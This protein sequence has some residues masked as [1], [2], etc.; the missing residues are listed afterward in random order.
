MLL[1]LAFGGITPTQARECKT[2]GEKNCTVTLRDGRGIKTGTENRG[3]DGKV[4]T[5]DSRGVKTGTIQTKP[6]S[7]CEIIRNSRGVKIG[8][9]GNC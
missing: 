9:R 1:A 5:R 3:N 7:N 2:A 4:T 6:K 8:T